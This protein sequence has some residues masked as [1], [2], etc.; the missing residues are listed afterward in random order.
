MVS[1]LN[2]EVTTLHYWQV[3]ANLFDGVGDFL[4]PVYNFIYDT[5]AALSKFRNKFELLFVV[6]ILNR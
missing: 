6:T 3:Q 1:E 2:S 4:Q 5:E